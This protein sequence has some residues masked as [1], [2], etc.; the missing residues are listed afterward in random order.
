MPHLPGDLLHLCLGQRADLHQCARII[1]GMVQQADLRVSR[2]C[3]LRRDA[4]QPVQRCFVQRRVRAKRHH[5]IELSCIVQSF[6]H[7]TEQQWQWQRARVIR[8]ERQHL[9]AGELTA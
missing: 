1:P 3:F 5:E 8:D 9:C 6:D 7:H 2:A 4:D